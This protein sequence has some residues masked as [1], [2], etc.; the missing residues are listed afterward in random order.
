MELRK[1]P[2][3]LSGSP[4]SVWNV[5]RDVFTKVSPATCW[6][7]GSR[8][9]RVSG[10]SA[11]VSSTSALVGSSTQSRRRSTV[12]GRITRPYSDCLYTPRSRSATD[13]MNPEWFLIASLLMPPLPRSE[14]P[15]G[16][17]AEKPIDGGVAL[18]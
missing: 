17:L 7:S 10:R 11:M 3:T 16:W 18:R 8:L 9:R 13:Q 15:D 6:S 5:C 1:F 2:A 4:S 14:R 12:K